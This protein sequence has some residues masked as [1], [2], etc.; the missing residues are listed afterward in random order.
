M[1]DEWSRKWIVFTADVHREGWLGLWDHLVSIVKRQKQLTVNEQFTCSL[2]LKGDEE[3]K[4]FGAQ[5]EESGQD[6]V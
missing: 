5:L 1:T 4:V 3:L 6:N 2:Y